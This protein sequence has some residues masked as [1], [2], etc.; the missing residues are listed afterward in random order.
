MSRF[1][2]LFLPIPLV[3]SLSGCLEDSN[4]QTAENIFTPVEFSV[5]SQGSQS[6]LSTEQYLVAKNEDRFNEIWLSVP[7]ISGD[8]PLVDFAENNVLTVL[9]SIGVCSGLEVTNV[10]EN[11]HTII[12]NLTEVVTFDPGLCDPSPEAFE[13]FSYAMIA[14]PKIFKNVSVV[15][16]YREDF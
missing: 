15:W 14:Y 3:F 13:N 1:I 8:V 12:F 7:S 11:E 16:G 9:S 10:E 4:A 2:N 5:I 6:D